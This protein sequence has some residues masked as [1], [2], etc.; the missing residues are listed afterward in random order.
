[1]V[2]FRVTI[3]VISLQINQHKDIFKIPWNNYLFD[4][5]LPR[6]W[7]AEDTFQRAM[8]LVFNFFSMIYIDDIL[9]CFKAD[10]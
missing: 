5:M 2:L 8:P 6:L 3:T 1:M 4:Q 10:K 7:S 9:I